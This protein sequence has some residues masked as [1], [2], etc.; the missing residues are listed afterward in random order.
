M[1]LAGPPRSGCYIPRVGT[2]VKELVLGPAKK[3]SGGKS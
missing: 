2:G 3:D 1:D